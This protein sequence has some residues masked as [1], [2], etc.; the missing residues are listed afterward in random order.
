MNRRIVLL[1]PPAAGKGTQAALIREHYG[2]PTVSTGAILRSE[3]TAGTELGEAAE[4]FTREGRLFPD[5]IA[6]QFVEKWIDQNGVEF[7][8]DGFP[9]TLSQAEALFALLAKKAVTLG[10]VIAFEVT[11]ETIRKRVLRRMVCEKCEYVE[12]ADVAARTDFRC[13]KCNGLLTRRKDDTLE[14]LRNR[15]IEYRVRT[16]PLIEYYRRRGFL[17]QV[18]SERAP[19]VVFRKVSEIVDRL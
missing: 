13:P 15:M 2:I 9:R 8:L 12:S 1:G 19:K 17:V 11:E 3:K 7:V 16:E 6:L 10:V 14:A 4:R 18:E 5:A